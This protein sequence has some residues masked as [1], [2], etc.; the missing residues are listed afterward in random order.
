MYFRTSKHYRP[1]HMH[2]MII[3]FAVNIKTNDIGLEKKVNMC[4]YCICI[5]DHKHETIW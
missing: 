5:F 3:F 1:T 4:L 2:K